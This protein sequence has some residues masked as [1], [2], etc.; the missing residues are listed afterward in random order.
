MSINY[1]IKG[2]LVHLKSRWYELLN[3]EFGNTGAKNVANKSIQDN[4]KNKEKPNSQ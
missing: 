3:K 1:I 4:G 2:H